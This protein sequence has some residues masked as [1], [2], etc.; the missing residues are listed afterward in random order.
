MVRNL[1]TFMGL[2]VRP[3][4][5]YLVPLAALFILASLWALPSHA[6][7]LDIPD[8]PASASH[9]PHTGMSMDTVQ[10]IWGEPSTRHETVSDP[11]TDNQPPINRWDY[12][13]FSVV[14]ERDLVIHTINP[15]RPPPVKN[16][17]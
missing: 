4:Y 8:Q 7:V 17:Q 3:I 14:F 5:S 13:S 10:K 2:A 15:Q 1:N 11:G 16:T 12:G 9:F 6:D